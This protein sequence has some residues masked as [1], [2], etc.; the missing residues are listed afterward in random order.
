MYKIDGPLTHGT[1]V[2]FLH[3]CDFIWISDGD[4]I[5]TASPIHLEASVLMSSWHQGMPSDWNL[6][7]SFCNADSQYGTS[8][9]ITYCKSTLQRTNTENLKQIF[10]EK[11]LRD[12]SSPNIHIHVSVSVLCIPT[13]DLPIL[14][15]EICELIL[16]TFKS[17]TDT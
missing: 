16:G 1:M 8:A 17:L 7:R 5:G 13:F 9:C 2:T 15:L 12:H 14:L 6:I 11:E 3:C 4:D 10:P